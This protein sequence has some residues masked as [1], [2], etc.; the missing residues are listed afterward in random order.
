MSNLTKG[1]W[2]SQ[3]KLSRIEALNLFTQGAAIAEFSE[4]KRGMIELGYEADLTILSNDIMTID[5]EKILNTD[6]IATIV[7]GNIVYGYNKF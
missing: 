2:Q 4:N 7:N 6:V 5:S 1:G 3:E